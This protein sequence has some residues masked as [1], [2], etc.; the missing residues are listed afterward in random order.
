MAVYEGT[1]YGRRKSS[2][3]RQ[4]AAVT[5]RPRKETTMTDLHVSSGRAWREKVR[6]GVVLQLPSGFVA[7]VVVSNRTHWSGWGG[8]PMR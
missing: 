1:T 3:T 5:I 4:A 7:R 6:E 8:F 2:S